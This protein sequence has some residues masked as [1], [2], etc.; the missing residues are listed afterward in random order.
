MMTSGVDA[1]TRVHH[2][3]ALTDT[4]TVRG[5]WRGTHT[6]EHWEQLLA[7]AGTV[8]GA[9]QWGVEG[10]WNYGRG[11]AQLLVAQRETVY[12]GTPRALAF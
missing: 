5:R 2:A 8:P 10:A 7:W 4:G 12:E 11:L 1:H 3:L 6:P 9:R